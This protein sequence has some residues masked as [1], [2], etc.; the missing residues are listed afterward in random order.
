MPDWQP[1]LSERTDWRGLFV[2]LPGTGRSRGSHDGIEDQADI[3][4]R[5]LEVLR[6]AFDGRSFAIAG[7]S[8]GAAVALAIARR[9]PHQV[10]G[11]A[12]RVPM[13]EPDDEARAQEQH[14]WQEAFDSLPAHYREAHEAKVASL[15][16]PARQNRID[17]EFLRSIRSDPL[18]YALPDTL[19]PVPP[20]PWPALVVFGRQDARVGWEQ[21]WST[22]SRLPRATSVVLDRADM[23]SR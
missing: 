20:F 12:V 2:D 1:I 6:Q 10:R 21:G 18:R 3:L 19:E 14:G 13:L 4:D 5:L 11:L 23:L 7:T 8:N 17:T 22:L 15:W 9:L 16:E